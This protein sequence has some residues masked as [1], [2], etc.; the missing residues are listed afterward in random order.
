MS[1][2]EGGEGNTMHIS[3]VRRYFFSIEIFS[4]LKLIKKGFLV[5]V[6]AYYVVFF[7][8]IIMS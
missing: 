6:G 4:V 3:S 8:F 5:A 1:C 7:V 2:N